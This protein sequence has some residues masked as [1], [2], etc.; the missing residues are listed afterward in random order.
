MPVVKVGP[1]ANFWPFLV[2]PLAVYNG[3]F[4]HC[5]AKLFRH[6][7]ALLLGHRGDIV[8]RHYITLS[9]AYFLFG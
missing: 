5:M 9:F 4:R 7:I 3:I 1:I 8:F 6:N 2:T